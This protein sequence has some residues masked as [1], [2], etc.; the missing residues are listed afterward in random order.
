L[1]GGALRVLTLGL[2]GGAPQGLLNRSAGR[3]TPESTLSS[4][5]EL[6]VDFNGRAF[7]HAYILPECHC[8]YRFASGR[9]AALSTPAT[10]WNEAVAGDGL[11]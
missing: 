9:D 7:D 5:E 1:A 2:L 8:T 3:G 11:A 10:A 4:R 6:L